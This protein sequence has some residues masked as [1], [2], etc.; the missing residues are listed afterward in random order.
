MQMI[1]A[2][3]N[4]RREQINDILF[5]IIVIIVFIFCYYFSEICLEASLFNEKGATAAIENRKR[6][7]TGGTTSINIIQYRAALC[8]PRHCRRL[9]LKARLVRYM[10]VFT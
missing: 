10:L 6:Q 1:D 2:T 5:N 3:I 8:R 7:T 9:Y 4:N